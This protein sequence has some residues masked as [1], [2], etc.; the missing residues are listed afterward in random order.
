MQ[1]RRD[2][3]DARHLLQ[4]L[5]LRVDVGD[6]RT[7]RLEDVDVRRG[8]EDAVAQLALQAGH[9]RQRDEQR[10]DADHHADDRD[11]RDERD[12]RL[13]APREQVAEGDEQLEGQIAHPH[14]QL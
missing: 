3:D 9:Q 2:A 14:A 6:A 5:H 10:H 13:L 12:E 7:R 8:A 1:R 4:L 11:E